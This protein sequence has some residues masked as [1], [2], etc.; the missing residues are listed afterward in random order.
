MAKIQSLKFKI[1]EATATHTVLT[2][3][4]RADSPNKNFSIPLY[5]QSDLFLSLFEA[6]QNA[7]QHSKKKQDVEVEIR[8]S[9]KQI[10]AKVYDEGEGMSWPPQKKKSSFSERGRGLQI[11]Q[12]LNDSVTYKKS[13]QRNCL[14]LHKKIIPASQ[15]IKPHELLYEVSRRLA[16]APNAARIHAIL[17]DHLLETFNA[18]RASIMLYD[19]SENALKVVAARGIP[20]NVRAAIRVK[21]GEGISGEVFLKSK[22]ILMKGAA[23]AKISKAKAE[24]KYYSHSFISAPMIA[25]PYRVGE[26]T[27]GVI[28]VTDRLDGSSFSSADLK[29]L[30]LLASQAAAYIQIGN[31]IEE[32]K[33]SESIR[34]DYEIVQEI[35]RKLPPQ[36]LPS[37]ESCEI[38]GALWIAEQGGGD[39]YD[40]WQQ[41]DSSWL[42]VADVSGHSIA[43]ALT[44]ANFRSSLR[45]IREQFNSPAELLNQLNQRL[46][47]DLSNAEQFICVSLV[48]LSPHSRE[49]SFC[50]AGCPPLIK[51]GR[52]VALESF[53]CQNIPLG[54]KMDEEYQE[55]V[56]SI[57]NDESLLLYSDGAIDLKNPNGKKLGLEGFWKVL[58][59]IQHSP[60]EAAPKLMALLKAY[61]QRDYPNDDVAVLV[62]KLSELQ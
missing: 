60:V 44:M 30:S 16:E 52:N 17:L 43:S 20:E 1:P 41:E 5:Y 54:V 6:I 62:A 31:M 19:S 61:S 51:F 29:L 15:K 36:K 26:Q 11:I 28:N 34:R 14:T 4:I 58:E 7:F 33:N 50:G 40:A 59:P 49:F 47:E 35:Q 9:S 55:H 21:K 57:Y 23:K 39:Y 10:E 3:Q 24:S 8:V 38:S 12:S 18:S 37:N 53:P 42:L 48:K 22:P 32:L 25:S 56:D 2:K 13:K 27:L 46:F 45:A